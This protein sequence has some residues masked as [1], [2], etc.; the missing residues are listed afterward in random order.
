MGVR[1]NPRIFEKMFMLR[2]FKLPMLENIVPASERIIIIVRIVL[3]KNGFLRLIF[4][5]VLE[6]N[7]PSRYKSA[8]MSIEY[9]AIYIL[10]NPL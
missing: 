5:E 8:A 4:K 10:F 1:E 9:V 3:A 7:N 2:R 6:Y